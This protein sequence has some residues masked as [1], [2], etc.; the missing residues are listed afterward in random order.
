MSQD[1]FEK[2]TRV[3]NRTLPHVSGFPQDHSRFPENRIRSCSSVVIGASNIFSNIKGTNG[4]FENW[5]ALHSLVC[6]FGLRRAFP[7]HTW[8]ER[9]D[10]FRET[11]KARRCCYYCH[12]SGAKNVVAVNCKSNDVT[13]N[14]RR[15][16]AFNLDVFLV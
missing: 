7:S 10:N 3:V 14:S 11:I 9:G 1:I 15:V 16:V 6:H 4:S 8:L 13:V 12:L 2:K 5:N